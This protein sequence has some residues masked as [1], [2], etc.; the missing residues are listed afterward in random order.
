MLCEPVPIRALHPAVFVKDKVTFCEA[1]FDHTAASRGEGVT[2]GRKREAMKFPSD[3]KTLEEESQ[4]LSPLL[5][6]KLIAKGNFS[7]KN[8]E[9]ADFL[10]LAMCWSCFCKKICTASLLEKR[11]GLRIL[12][13]DCGLLAPFLLE[14]YLSC[15]FCN[16]KG[17]VLFLLD[18]I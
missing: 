8:F 10:C 18:F 15:Q 14:K 11:F 7:C 3:N 13:L 2:V 4:H 1:F 6:N 17:M 16:G 9:E 12:T 5:A